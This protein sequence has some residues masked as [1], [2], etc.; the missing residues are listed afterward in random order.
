MSETFVNWTSQA[1]IAARTAQQRRSQNWDEQVTCGDHHV[2][3]TKGEAQTKAAM[4]FW[5]AYVI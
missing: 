1:A 5:Q 3:F 2:P 4:W